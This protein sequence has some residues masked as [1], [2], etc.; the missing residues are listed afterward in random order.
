MLDPEDDTEKEHSFPNDDDRDYAEGF[1]SI[2]D[3][4]TRMSNSRFHSFP[5]LSLSRSSH[6]V[7]LLGKTE[8]KPITNNRPPEK[9][10]KDKGQRSNQQRQVSSRSLISMFIL[11]QQIQTIVIRKIKAGRAISS[12]T[13]FS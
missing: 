1:S 6:L 8:K 5:S 12:L 9:K 11:F 13:F 4:M 2:D 7:R 10:V 3:N